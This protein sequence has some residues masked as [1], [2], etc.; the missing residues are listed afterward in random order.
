MPKLVPLWTDVAVWLL[1]ACAAAYALVVL[2]S[3]SL[4]ANWRKVF[5]DAGVL[6][7]AV[8]LA[9]C[10]VITVADS[11][12]YRP[13]LKPAV[14]WTTSSRTAAPETRPRKPMRR[15]SPDP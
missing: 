1:V 15:S 14:P 12:H 13:L 9:I 3:P 2:R 6:C 5:R 11:V 8:I 4:R 10:L 7:S